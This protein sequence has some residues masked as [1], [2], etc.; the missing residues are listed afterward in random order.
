MVVWL[1]RLRKV[2][3]ATRLDEELGRAISTE[4]SVATR[5]CGELEF[6]ISE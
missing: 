6:A 4:V 5:L 1:R 3:V 2:R